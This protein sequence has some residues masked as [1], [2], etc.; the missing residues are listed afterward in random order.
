M[1]SSDEMKRE[2]SGSKPA[3]Q[4]GLLKRIGMGNV[5]ASAVVGLCLMGIFSAQ[6]LA[7]ARDFAEMNIASF[8]LFMVALFT[9]LIR[10]AT[11]QSLPRRLRMVPL[12]AVLLAM[13]AMAAI[14]RIDRVDGRLVPALRFRWTPKPDQ[15]LEVPVFADDAVDVD[16]GE[17]ADKYAFPQFLGPDRNLIITSVQLNRD[18]ESHAP[19]EM[20]RQPIGA[21]WCG[22][23][24]VN[25]FAFTMEQRGPHELITCYEIETGTPRWSHSVEARHETVLGGVGP[26][27][28]PTLLGRPGSFGALMAQPATSCGRTTSSHVTASPPNRI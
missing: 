21:G 7:E 20:W 8:L 28:T 16:L 9:V 15:L 18:W 2:G 12:V 5:I 10:I 26:R 6:S 23:S 14:F 11:S 13:I 17:P 3:Y 25:G 1:A 24:A 27:C 19:Q 4:P 22:F